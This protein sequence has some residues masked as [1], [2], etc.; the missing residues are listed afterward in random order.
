MAFAGLV[1]H[2][3][4]AVVN[5]SLVRGISEQGF[6]RSELAIHEQKY[7]SAFPGDSCYW[8]AARAEDETC[9]SIGVWV[10]GWLM[11]IAVDGVHWRRPLLFGTSSTIFENN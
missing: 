4:N 11:G 5:G 1:A 8:A 6:V 9:A 10:A 7:T 2:N 3:S